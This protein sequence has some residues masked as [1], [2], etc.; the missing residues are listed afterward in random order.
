MTCKVCTIILEKVAAAQKGREE[1]AIRL[2]TIALKIK[3]CDYIFLIRAVLKF[4][5]LAYLLYFLE[6]DSNLL[7]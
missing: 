1:H 7:S 4:M 5:R 3:P 2:Q 6:F